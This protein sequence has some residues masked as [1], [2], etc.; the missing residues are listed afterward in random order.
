MPVCINHPLCLCL[1]ALMCLPLW[2]GAQTVAEVQSL[3]DLGQYQ[4]AQEAASRLI[5]QSPRSSEAYRLRGNARR[6]LNELSNALEDYNRA[7]EFDPS[8]YRAFGGRAILKRQLKDSSGALAD[9]EKALALNSSYDAGYNFRA[10]LRLDSGKLDAALADAGRAIELNPRNASYYVRRAS[11][12]KAMKHPSDAITDLSR[13]IEINPKD[14][15]AYFQRSQARADSGDTAGALEDLNRAIQMAPDN[16]NYQ[17]RRDVLRGNA[18]PKAADAT[19]TGKV[20]KTSTTTDVAT[21]GTTAIGSTSVA[22]VSSDAVSISSLSGSSR[23][24][25]STKT[26]ETRTDP[27]D[28]SP[29]IQP[30][31][32]E[33]PGNPKAG[34]A[35]G[36]AGA[37]GRLLDSMG[38][39]RPGGDVA[40]MMVLLRQAGGPLTEEE[41][42]AMN[43]Q[44]APYAASKSPK[45]H[46]AIRKQSELLLESML[47]RQLMVQAAWEYDFAIAQRQ[48]AVLMKDNEE[49]EIAAAVAELQEQVVAQSRQRLDA[50]SQE[51]DKFPDIPTPEELQDEDEAERRN[52]LEALSLQDAPTSGKAMAGMLKYEKTF[53]K[54]NKPNDPENAPVCEAKEKSMIYNHAF[55]FRGQKTPFWSLKSECTWQIPQMIPVYQG[56]SDFP[57]HITHK[58]LGSQFPAMERRI[59][60]TDP[61]PVACKTYVGFEQSIDKRPYGMISTSLGYNEKTLSCS[62]EKLDAGIFRSEK[63]GYVFIVIEGPGGCYRVDICYKWEPGAGQATPVASQQDPGLGDDKNAQIAEHEANIAAAN[64]ALDSIRREMGGETDGKRREELRLQALHLEQDVHDCNDLIQSIKTGTLVKTR[65]PWDEHATAVMARTSM[66]MVEDCRRAQQM[67]ASF[68]RMTRLLEKYKPEEGRKLYEKLRTQMV[69]GIYQPGGLQKAQKALDTLYQSTSAVLGENQGQN[70]ADVQLRKAQLERVERNLAIAESVKKNCDRAIFAGTFFTGMGAGIALNMVYEASCTTADKGAKTALKNAAF[71]G[72]ILL[73]GMGV[74]KAGGWAIGKFLNPKVA[75]SEVNTFKNFLEASRHQQEMEWNRALVSQL[76]DKARALEKCKTSGG[77]DYLKIR[78]ELDEAVAAANSSS[79]AKNIMKNEFTAAE[80]ALDTGTKEATAAFNEVN[81]YQKLYN[82]RLQNSIYPRTDAQMVKT[83]Q[84][85][86]YNVQPGWLREFRNAS[87]R[88]ANRDRDLGLLAQYEGKL[89]KNGQP[90]SLNEF[91]TDGQKAYNS[92]YKQV[93]GRSATLAD[94]NITTTAHSESFPLSWLEKKVSGAGDPRDFEKAGS[95][96]YNKVKNA[97][98]GPD[99]AF[100]NLKKACS[101]LGK[102]LKTKVLPR[103]ETPGAASQISATSRQAALEHWNEVQKVLDNFGSDKID[104]LTA[105][106]ELQKLTGSTSITQ[107]AAQVKRLMARLGGAGT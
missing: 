48:L 88:A 13:A 106:K 45:A 17:A 89:T 87:S 86:G 71:Q 20:T 50:L 93:T 63:P 4:A 70:L 96:I 28:E 104:P 98:A 51:I 35:V 60:R 101:S 95:A 103:L 99:P 44:W 34:W 3:V 27:D 39:G 85:Q 23:N 1:L 90:V 64:R 84:Q 38:G 82:Q 43:K 81:S 5:T 102:D 31:S 68:V 47:H 55:F 29:C 6:N 11:I 72:G 67:Q 8:S 24:K 57:F 73:G 54:I 66:E 37:P 9:V 21:S 16:S 105:M 30:I 97:M 32:G 53:V 12:H 65:G 107:S 100:V 36:L 14:H 2:S 59:N 92:S 25:P 83:L 40:A 75:Q 56:D 80:K 76:K 26:G 78:G 61:F 58:D 18:R 33:E 62:V 15:D 19:R 10:L 77:K 79:L 46:K 74:M 91:M 7:V 69:Q 22:E 41:D 49:A 94:Q 42:Q 52:A